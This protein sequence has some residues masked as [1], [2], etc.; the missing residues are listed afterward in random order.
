M[1]FLPPFSLLY[2]A[3]A[4]FN[5]YNSLRF[6]SSLLPALRFEYDGEFSLG[7]CDEGFS[8]P[9]VYSPRKVLKLAFARSR[10]GKALGFAL[11]LTHRSRRGNFGRHSQRYST[12]AAAAVHLMSL[13]VWASAR[14]SSAGEGGGGAPNMMAIYDLRFAV[15]FCGWSAVWRAVAVS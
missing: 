3:I 6:L 13:T 2:N 14:S 12:A 5:M 1:L 8:S 7:E 4:S 10:R 9:W 11:A 15:L